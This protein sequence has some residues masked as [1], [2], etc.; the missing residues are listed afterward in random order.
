ME[1][2]EII[3]VP[4]VINTINVRSELFR[5]YQ[6]FLGCVQCSI[7]CFFIEISSNSG[8]PSMAHHG[9][10]ETPSLHRV[11]AIVPRQRGF[12]LLRNLVLNVVGH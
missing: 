1:I 6:H 9:T 10:L 5:T 4:L 3:R 7:R 11:G 12:Q 2:S 8:T